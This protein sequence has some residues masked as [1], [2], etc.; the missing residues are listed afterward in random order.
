[1]EQGL[2][3]AGME[4]EPP[5]AF[6][7]CCCLF[8]LLPAAPADLPGQIQLLLAAQDTEHRLG[9]HPLPAV[10]PGSRLRRA[11]G[12]TSS[13]LGSRSWGCSGAL[14]LLFA[15]CCSPAAD[16]GL[17]PSSPRSQPGHRCLSLC[18]IH[19]FLFPHQLQVLF[20]ATETLNTLLMA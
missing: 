7:R 10:P 6:P 1:M 2:T 13:R 19:F 16:T 17:F 14:G 3:P 5:G 15:G 20:Y 12:S 4:P 11:P 18:S 8:R 9:A